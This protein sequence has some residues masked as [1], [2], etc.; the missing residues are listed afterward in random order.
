MI[1]Q[2]VDI[3]LRAAL[4]DG[5]SSYMTTPCLPIDIGNALIP[6]LDGRTAP[7]ISGH[8]RTFDIL[9]AEDN[10][11]NQRLAVRIL[12]KYNHTVDVANNG[13]EAFEA[14][15]KKRYDV[16]LMDVQMPVMGGF[17]ATGK[18]REWEREQGLTPTPVV[19]L[20]A[21]AMVGDREKCLAAKMDDYL[22]KPLNQNQLIQAIL[23]CTAL[24]G[25]YLEHQKDHRMPRIDLDQEIEDKFHVRDESRRDANG[26]SVEEGN[27]RSKMLLS[28]SG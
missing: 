19:A 28:Q 17:E 22:S 6:A 23:K 14:V 13:L 15:K 20:T 27:T 5:I 11:V 1:T 7:L 12:K 21:H 25:A 10:A 3:S 4:E 16:V 26:G 18:I 9:L 8:L 24:G 2:K